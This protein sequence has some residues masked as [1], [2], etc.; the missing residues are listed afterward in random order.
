MPVASIYR[1]NEGVVGPRQLYAPKEASPRGWWNEVRRTFPELEL[2]PWSFVKARTQ[3]HVDE[4]K[5]VISFEQGALD[6][7]IARKRNMR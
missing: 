3:F 5:D 2:Q 4:T 1:A 6:V 7:W